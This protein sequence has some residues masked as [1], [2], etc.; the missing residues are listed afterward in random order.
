MSVGEFGG[1]GG[2]G[3]GG[4][5]SLHGGISPFLMGKIKFLRGVKSQEFPLN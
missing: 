4:N 3:V 2:G 5:I 1:G